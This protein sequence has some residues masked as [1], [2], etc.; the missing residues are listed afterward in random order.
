MGYSGS[1]WRLD[2]SVKYGLADSYEVIGSWQNCVLSESSMLI[3]RCP[4]TGTIK[5]FLTENGIYMFV[6]IVFF[7]DKG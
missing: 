2:N 1:I 7:K 4:F 5:V 3:S 6:A